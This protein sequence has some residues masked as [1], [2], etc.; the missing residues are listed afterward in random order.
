MVRHNH[1]G[2]DGRLLCQNII[3]FIEMSFNEN[4]LRF[5]HANCVEEV[6]WNHP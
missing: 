3:L 1:G 4:E 6:H 2:R 5:N